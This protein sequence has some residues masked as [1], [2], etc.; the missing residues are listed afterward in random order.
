M[1]YHWN[2]SKQLW[3]DETERK[4]RRKGRREVERRGGREEDVGRNENKKQLNFKKSAETP[5]NIYK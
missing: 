3:I 4:R 5:G 2:F 1:Y